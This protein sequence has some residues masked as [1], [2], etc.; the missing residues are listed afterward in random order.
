MKNK[1]LLALW[2]TLGLCTGLANAKGNGQNH[3]QHNRDTDKNGTI[4]LEEFTANRK[5]PA[6][7]K[8]HF[9][10]AD[11]DH[12]GQ[13]DKAERK[14]LRQ[15]HNRAAKAKHKKQGKHKKNAHHRKAHRN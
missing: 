11:T 5:H 14:A 10:A 15:K 12:N 3:P 9:E 6:K 13:L 4:S 8:A 2:V 1:S 7:A